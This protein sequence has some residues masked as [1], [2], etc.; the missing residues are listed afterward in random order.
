MVYNVF[1]DRVADTREDCDRGST[2]GDSLFLYDGGRMTKPFLT[3]AQQIDKLENEKQLMIPDHSYAEQTLRQIGYF[4]LISGYKMP[5]K[6]PTTKKYRDGTTFEDVVALYKFDE[7]LR[8]LFLKYIL[9]V[10]RHLRSLLSYYF[11]KKHGEQQIHYLHPTNYSSNR[12]DQAAVNR[13]I[14]K[15]SELVLRNQDYPYLNHHRD[16]YHNIPLWVLMNAVT[17]GSLS[18]FYALMTHDLQ[19][20]VAQNFAGVNERQL[21]QYLNVITKFRNVCAHNERLF[22]YQTYSDI[23]DTTLH[24]KL[25]I[26]QTG[27]QYVYGKRDLFALV[28]AL[29]YLLPNEDFKKFKQQLVQ[30][31][32][33]YFKQSSALTESELLGYMGFPENWGKITVYRK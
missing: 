29:R 32:R 23:P 12:R 8:E 3:Y 25:G 13:L 20:K 21:E 28:I 26:P 17:F 2:C 19:A 30:I 14:Q 16:T 22:S 7:N 1:S 27:T 18:K 33:H 24:Q 9:R 5:F 31:I 6:N 10:E 15:L 4:A 11:S